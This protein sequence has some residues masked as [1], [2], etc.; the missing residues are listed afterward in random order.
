MKPGDKEKLNQC[1]E[2][3]DT[4]DL[5]LSMVWLWTWSTIKENLEGGDWDQLVSEDEAWTLLCEA[6]ES[7]AGF[8]LAF[9]A[10]QHAEDVLDWMLNRGLIGDFE[11]LEEDEDGTDETID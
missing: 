8:T 2:I 6:I 5:G 7:G 10:D 11:D 4:T 1:L 9:G 3:L